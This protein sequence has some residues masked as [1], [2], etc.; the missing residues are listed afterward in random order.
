MAKHPHSRRG[1][2]A[3]RPRKRAK[4]Q[5]PRVGAWPNVSETKLLGFAGYKAGMTQFAYICDDNSPRKDKEVLTSATI[6]E[7]PPMTVYGIRFYGFDGNVIS[8]YL[9]DNKKILKQIGLGDIK[10]KNIPEADK[11]YSVFAL[12]FA[13][14]KL[15]GFG[16]KKPEPME[17]AIGGSDTNAKIEYVK[18][19]LGKDI[20]ISDIAKPG[21]YFDV[22]SV[23]KGKGWQGPVKRFGI[24][25]HRRKATGKRRHIGNLGAFGYKNV[26]FT[27]P[28]AG[29]MGYHKR[30]EK[31][32]RLMKILSPKD[33]NIKGGFLRYGIV[34][35]QALLIKGSIPG[36][37]K[38][39][40]RL[41]FALNAPEPKEPKITYI[42]NESVQ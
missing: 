14:P 21:D 31:N 19:L 10:Q 17:I 3:F 41:R 11:I 1:S 16:K 9:T 37:A 35:N 24:K 23:T 29:Q 28:Q 42:A 22:V 27:V 38:R 33:A 6:I 36:P 39:L 32:K 30:T 5:K 20:Q 4:S 40:I 7:V 25:V 13:K 15:T 26:F 8:D 34:K 2:L 18:S 12:C